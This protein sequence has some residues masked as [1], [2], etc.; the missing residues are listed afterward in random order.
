MK[1][2]IKYPTTFLVIYV[3]YL[4][5][6]YPLEKL[7]INNGLSEL[8]SSF[9]STII[10]TIP[11]LISLVWLM[12][13]LDFKK[14]NG[15]DNGIKLEKPKF[16]FLP[17]LFLFYI[18]YSDFSSIINSETS[19]L[20]LLVLSVILVGFSEEFF[21]R[22]ILLPLF[23]TNFKNKNGFIFLSVLLSSLIFGIVHFLNLLNNP[24]NILG[25]TVQVI[26]A[27]CIGFLFSGFI[28]KTKSI[29]I[30][31]LI[32][33]MVNFK[34]MIN[35]LDLKVPTKISEQKLSELPELPEETIWVIFSEL[36]LTFILLLLGG[37]MLIRKI[38]KK[39]LLERLNI[40][41][42]TANSI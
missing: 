37:Y 12:R 41:S 39:E 27:F 26:F 10:I 15:I 30:P 14:F 32:H 6:R 2:D 8:K 16:L 34:G 21:F 35:Y 1:K 36:D 5:L 23:L 40:T 4:L 29:I 22:G 17:L 19:A 38:N 3:P 24:E 31:S 28:L 11:L 25:V 7:L 20:L 33:A 9:I 42:T 13:K 18:F